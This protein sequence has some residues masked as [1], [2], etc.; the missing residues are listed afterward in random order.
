MSLGLIIEGIPLTGKT[1]LLTGLQRHPLFLS[2]A[3]VSKLIY[4][5]DLTQRVLE[6]D[7]NRGF[8][9][10]S[11]N[12]NLLMS[13][14]KGL[15]EHDK[16][17]HCRGFA[18]KDLLFI[19]ERFHLT[20]AAY[21]PYLTWNDVEPIDQILG[22]LKTK[23][24]LLSVDRHTF[25]NRLSERN[26]TGFM[27]YIQRYGSNKEMILDHYMQSQDRYLKLVH[28]SC[29]ETKIIDSVTS[30]VSKVLESALDFWLKP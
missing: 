1:T 5:E 16:M 22:C 14:T 18:S 23:L 24:I 21:Y 2:Y 4:S 9:D 19:L 13:I 12:L 29:L 3:A 26:N 7:Y 27:S 10:K 30:P 17:L 6:K 28:Q 20:H 15:H 8:L 11:A 25:E